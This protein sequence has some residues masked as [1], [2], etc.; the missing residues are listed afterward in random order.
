MN[1]E[2]QALVV[3]LGARVEAIIQ[4][5]VDERMG[6]VR[7]ALHGEAMGRRLYASGQPAGR[8]RLAA[9]DR[10]KIMAEARAPGAVL[11]DVERRHALSRG[12]LQK[13]GVYSGRPPGS[14]K[15]GTKAKPGPK[16]RDLT[17]IVAG[18]DE[19][20]NKAAKQKYLNGHG[21]HITT[22]YKWKR[23]HPESPASSR[24]TYSPEQRRSIAMKAASL[25]P[26]ERETFLSNEGVSKETYWKWSA[27]AKKHP[28]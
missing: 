10:A 19:F 9:A 7:A 26:G 6:A 15:A 24:K 4:R 3:D 27:W 28:V 20:P 2:V 21:V 25:P 22:Y 1:K 18:A 14:R 11:A 13:W 17:A 8:K 12:L 16:R 5:V 23:D